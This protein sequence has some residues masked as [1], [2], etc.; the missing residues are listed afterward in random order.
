[1]AVPQSLRVLSTRLIDYAGL[2]PPAKLEM[3]PAVEAYARHIRSTHEWMLGSFICPV[4]RLDELTKSAAMV[5]PGTFATSGYRE[6]AD[7]LPAWRISAIIPAQDESGVADA[8]EAIDTFNQRH[9]NEEN[10]LAIIDAVELKASE[11]GFID[12]TVELIPEDI[13]PFY[14]FDTTGDVRGYVAALAGDN[15]AAKIRCG[16]VTADLIPS[17]KQIANFVDACNAGG[18]PFKATAGLHHPIRSEHPLTYEDDAPRGVM[19]GF[20]NVFL[21]SALLRAREIDRNQLIELLE[22]GDPGSF[23]F[24]DQQASWRGRSVDLSR[25][26]KARESFAV[27]YGS[28]SFD[29]PTADL[30]SLGL[31]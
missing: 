4:S 20:I 13:R 12:E 23:A 26:N 14:E 3:P 1:M 16:G 9:S 27:G 22:D 18:V 21:G 29:E 28:C 17:S 31:L 24:D 10:G 25:L 6:M 5:M 15:A 7:E 19:H 11:P 30:K 2:F 8:I